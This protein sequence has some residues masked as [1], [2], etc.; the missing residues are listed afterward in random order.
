[1]ARGRCHPLQARAGVVVRARGAEVTA[2]ASTAQSSGP[3]GLH[4]EG[5]G[6]V[7]QW[8]RKVMT[9]KHR[10]TQPFKLSRDREKRIFGSCLHLRKKLS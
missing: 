7:R 8:Q 4:K 2:D 6:H 10:A 3:A 9:T 1:M 5:A